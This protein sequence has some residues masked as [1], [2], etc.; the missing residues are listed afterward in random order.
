[1]DSRWGFRWIIRSG[2]DIGNGQEVQDYKC[3][4]SEEIQSLFTNMG[5]TPYL[6]LHAKPRLL[7]IKRFNMIGKITP[8]REEPTIGVHEPRPVGGMNHA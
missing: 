8:P 4:D 1:M 2:D 7:F 5:D 6:T 3:H